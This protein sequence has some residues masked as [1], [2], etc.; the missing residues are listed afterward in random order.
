MPTP[1]ASMPGGIEVPPRSTA[2]R[3]KA[4]GRERY[5]RQEIR[6][7]TARGNAPP[8]DGVMTG[9][10]VKGTVSPGLTY[11]LQGRSFG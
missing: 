6:R 1:I 2:E 5:I 3:R 4:L 9:V 8:G 10:G 11:R 7:R